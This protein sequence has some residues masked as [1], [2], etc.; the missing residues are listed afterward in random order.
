MKMIRTLIQLNKSNMKKNGNMKKWS[1][2]LQCK[3]HPNGR[4]FFGKPLYMTVGKSYNSFFL[5]RLIVLITVNGN[6]A[7]NIEIS[8]TV[9]CGY[10]R[11]PRIEETVIGV[12]NNRIAPKVPPIR[13]FPLNFVVFPCLRI[14]SIR[15]TTSQITANKTYER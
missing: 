3:K 11:L 13:R 7:K 5:T 9:I 1:G 14:V 15:H 2:N 6:N 12:I 4:C 10:G 8:T